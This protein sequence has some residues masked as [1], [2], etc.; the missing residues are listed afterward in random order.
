MAAARGL[1]AADRSGRPV[2]RGKE[3]V[4]GRLHLDAT[5]PSELRAHALVVRSQEL[6]PSRV[7]EFGCLLGRIHDVGEQNRRE[8]AVELGALAGRPSGTPRSRRAQRPDRPPT[9]GGRRHRV[10]RAS[11]PGCAPR[12]TSPPP[13]GRS[14]SPVRCMISVGTRIAGRIGRA[15]IS[16]FIRARVSAACGLALL[17]QI[18][19]PEPH[20]S[21]IVGSARRASGAPDGS[22]PALLDLVQSTLRDPQGTDPRDSRALAAAARNS[23]YM[24]S[25]NVRSG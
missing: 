7:P 13:C 8:H 21:V 15:S 17:H 25:A 22:A 10:G 4:A 19:G 2:E 9:G 20:E 24:M 1:G 6:L 16:A 3:P 5:E 11:L 14:W 23:P 18:R 12:D